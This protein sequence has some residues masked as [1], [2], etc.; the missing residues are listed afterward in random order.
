[1]RNLSIIFAV[2]F[3]LI[4]AFQNIAFSQTLFQKKGATNH[5]IFNPS[6]S[7]QNENPGRSFSAMQKTE[8]WTELADAW[9]M[10]IFLYAINPIMSVEINGK[11]KW[12][13]T[14]EV[15][16]GFGKLGQFR[17]S[18]EYSWIDFEYSQNIIR[19]GLKYDIFLKSKIN[20]LLNILVRCWFL[21]VFITKLQFRIFL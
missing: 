9:L 11:L 15:S 1:M 14:K 13:W 12:G 17:T 7:N 5:F 8:D 4:L 21:K 19:A 16:L 2:V 6:V 18:V 3:T 10:F 20:H